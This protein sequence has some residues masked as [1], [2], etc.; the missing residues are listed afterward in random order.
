MNIRIYKDGRIHL[1]LYGRLYTAGSGLR[2][3]YLYTYMI[4]HKYNEN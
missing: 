2:I 1:K 3:K 4:K